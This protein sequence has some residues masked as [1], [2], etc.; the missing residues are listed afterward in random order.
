VPCTSLFLPRLSPCCEQTLTTCSSSF[1]SRSERVLDR[2]LYIGIN[3][4]TQVELTDDRRQDIIS[5]MDQLAAEGLRVLA[6]SAKYEP[7]SREEEY[8]TMPRDEMEKGFCF[9]G[10]VGIYDPPRPQ[11]KGAVQ[12]CIAAGIVPRMLTGSFFL[13]FLSLLLRVE[14][15]CAELASPSFIP[16]GD[17]PATA[18]AISLAVG[19]IDNQSP[20]ECVMTGQEFDALSEDQID[21]MPELPLVIARCAP[22]T[23]VRMVEALHRRLAHGVYRTT[24][25]T[26]DGVNDCPALK[27]ADIG[28]AMGESS[29]LLY[30]FVWQR[31]ANLCVR[32]LPI[33][34]SMDPTSPR[35]LPI[36][37]SPTTTSQPSS[38]PSERD[39]ESS[40][41]YPRSV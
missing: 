15:F 20:K 21:A 10:L 28:V 8:K 30:H 36:S 35:E 40:P 18:R 22:E 4:D 33:Q 23:K 24:I 27:R 3:K 34:V 25:M 9:L 5:R 29:T 31:L 17:H 1:H 32:Y 7:G 26:G 41:T 14:N 13:L 12:D 6:L 2:C 19:I 16:A 38:E 11:S 37:F 39:E